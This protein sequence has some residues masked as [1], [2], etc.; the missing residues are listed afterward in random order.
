MIET[1][2]QKAIEGG[3]AGYRV[4]QDRVFNETE[5]ATLAKSFVKY[6]EVHLMS[7]YFWRALSKACKWSYS[8][9]GEASNPMWNFNAMRFFEINL[10]ESFE[11]AVAYL[12]ALIEKE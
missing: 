9:L 7:P 12:S 4:N 5:R 11:A 3:Y 2:I 10:T 6:K 8:E 1:I